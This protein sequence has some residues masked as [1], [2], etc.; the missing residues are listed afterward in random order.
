[1]TELKMEHVLLLAVAAFLMYHLLG[2]C[3]F[4]RGDGFNVGGQSCGCNYIVDGKCR[5]HQ[6]GTTFDESLCNNLKSE[7]DC[8]NQFL[9]ND[10]G[11]DICS[12]DTGIDKVNQKLDTLTNRFDEFLCQIIDSGTCIDQTKIENCKIL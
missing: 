3:G 9:G 10:R 12:W 2:G 8:T 11:L 4:N 5:Q 1:M 6:S 7:Y